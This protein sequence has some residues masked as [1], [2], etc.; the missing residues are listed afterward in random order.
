MGNPCFLLT[1]PISFTLTILLSKSLTNS[2]SMSSISL[3]N[4]SSPSITS[5]PFHHE[6]QKNKCRPG[7]YHRHRP[8]Q[9]TW[10]MA[11][12]NGQGGLLHPLD[13]HRSLLLSNGGGG[14]DGG[15]K[16]DGHSG[17]DPPKDPPIMIG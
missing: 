9:D 15:I 11:S 10:V 13:I 14:F 12:P 5:P 4:G 7:F 1:F 3:L 8:G 16:E 2:L 6:V 17:G